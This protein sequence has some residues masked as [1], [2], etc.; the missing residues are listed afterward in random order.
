MRI[1]Q[2][3]AAAAIGTALLATA[4]PSTA[5]GSTYTV[6]VGGSSA[7]AS[8]SFTA[9]S[10][11][12]SVWKVPTQT[13]S[14]S[15]ASVPAS[16]PSIVSAGEDVTDLLTL[17]RLNFV[18]CA[19]F[20][21]ARLVTTATPWTFH[22]TGS[23]APAASDVVAGHI[24]GFN[25]TWSIAACTFTVSGTARASFDEAAQKLVIAETGFTGNLIV[26]NV[27]GCLGQITNGQPL[28][29][30]GT[31]NVASPDGLINLS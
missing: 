6:A 19:A 15:S 14:C 7:P 3:L 1:K 25:A 22:G 23:A 21:G 11:G 31:F 26:S 13:M 20:G 10:A 5:N 17:N 30:T 24:D 2:A 18:G 29:L 9:T 28:D 12:A 4:G 27:T 8:H 16:P